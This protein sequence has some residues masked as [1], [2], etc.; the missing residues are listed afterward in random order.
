MPWDPEKDGPIGPWLRGGAPLG[1]G[2]TADVVIGKRT[3][4]TRD[5]VKEGRTETG[6]RYKRV[7]DQLGH[8]VTERTDSRG[9]QHRDVRINLPLG[10]G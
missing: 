9:G 4:R 2:R 3:W 5:Q 10:A 8:E 7:T 1:E 6:E